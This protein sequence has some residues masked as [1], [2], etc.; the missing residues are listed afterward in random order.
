MDAESLLF[1]IL[2]NSQEFA[3]GQSSSTNDVP[4]KA[5]PSIPGKPNKY[6][7]KYNENVNTIN[8]ESDDDKKQMEAIM[9]P[10]TD[11]EISPSGMSKSTT[12]SS[13]NVVRISPVEI[14]NDSKINTD[15]TLYSTVRTNSNIPTIDNKSMSII[16]LFR[17]TP[18][19]KL[20]HTENLNIAT[21]KTTFDSIS[22][23]K[24]EKEENIEVTTIQQVQNAKINSKTSSTTRKPSKRTTKKKQLN[25]QIQINR[26]S[27]TKV[28]KSTKTNAKIAQ[29]TKRTTT[30]TTTTQ[31][32]PTSAPTAFETLK[33]S[34]LNLFP[35]NFDMNFNIFGIFD[36]LKGF[37]S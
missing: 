23:L 31:S 30:S 12:P 33:R 9:G 14:N 21:I 15:T 17:T 13:M 34:I 35:K 5:Q 6:S 2:D 19:Y 11:Y 25:K 29:T 4:H 32:P 28:T 8:T 7:S 1:L 26:K 18:S 10:S 37:L 20:N 22:D 24:I 16:Q 3:S 36:F 27:I